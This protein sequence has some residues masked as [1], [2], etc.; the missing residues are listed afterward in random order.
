LWFNIFSIANNHAMDGWKT[1]HKSTINNLEENEFNY[2]WY[3]RHGKI[4]ENNY[5]FTWSIGDVNFAWHAYDFTIYGDNYLNNYCEDL[6]NY[7]KDW[8]ENFVVVHWWNE[9]QYMT[10]SKKQE[11]EAK[12]LIDCG[13]NLIIWMHTHVI[14]DIWEYNWV[15]IIYSL[16]NFLFD[17]NWSEN[18]QKWIGVF[19]EYTRGGEIKI[20]TKERQVSV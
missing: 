17:Q 10:H 5:V 19:I 8:F 20:E 14:Q 16:G 2:F 6:K 18:T 7:K 3:I 11:A 12:K 13:A 9:Y 1:A 15:P 4:F